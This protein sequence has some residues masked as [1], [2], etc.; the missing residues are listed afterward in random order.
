[1]SHHLPVTPLIT[2]YSYLTKVEHKYMRSKY[3]SVITTCIQH[4]MKSV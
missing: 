4:Y 2:V 1:M 3:Q